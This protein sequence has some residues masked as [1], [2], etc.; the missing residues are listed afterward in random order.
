ME[1]L[2]TIAL[3][4]R[5][6]V[7]PREELSDSAQL[8]IIGTPSSACTMRTSSVFRRRTARHLPGRQPLN[9]MV[10]SMA[11]PR[12]RFSES[13]RP[14]NVARDEGRVPRAHAYMGQRGVSV[15]LDRAR[16]SFHG[17]HDGRRLGR[18]LWPG[19]SEVEILRG[20][21]DG[22][23]RLRDV[24]PDP[25]RRLTR[26]VRGDGRE[27]EDRMRHGGV[28]RRLELTSRTATTR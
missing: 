10:S 9:L 7:L 14:S 28:A 12:C 25:L 18:R 23:P 13:Q 6:V 27:C 1:Y 17:R 21:R 2:G 5:G 24:V 16:T 11:K 26:Y 19:M 22:A 8:R 15:K 20:L 3:A 4:H